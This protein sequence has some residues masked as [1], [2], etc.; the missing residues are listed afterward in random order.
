MLNSCKIAIFD[1]TAGK[2][3]LLKNLQNDSR[4]VEIYCEKKQTD[5]GSRGNIKNKNSHL[6]S[7][8]HKSFA[9]NC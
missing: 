7:L 6:H 2:K 5:K 9:Y 3:K 4:R 8:M 1:T